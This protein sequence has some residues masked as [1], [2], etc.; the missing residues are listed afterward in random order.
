MTNTIGPCKGNMIGDGPSGKGLFPASGGKLKKILIVYFQRPPIIEYLQKAFKGRGIEAR[1]F[2][3]DSNNWFDQFVIRPINKTAHNLRI[4]PKNRFLFEAHPLCQL[5]YRNRKLI[6]EVDTFCPDLVL[7][8]R[9]YGYQHGTLAEVRRRCKLFGWWIEREEGAE[10]AIAEAALFDYY[11]FLHSSAVTLAKK[12]GLGKI[13]HIPHSVDTG[14]FRP[15]GLA[16]KYDWSFVGGWSEAREEFIRKAVAVSSN[17][18]LYGP[19]WK[20]KLQAAGKAAKG[21]AKGDSIWG[22][23][24]VRLYNESRV[25]INHTHWGLGG[26]RERTGLTMRVLEAA[27]CGSCMLT[28]GSADLTSL[29]TPGKDV[30][31]YKDLDDFSAELKR[32]LTNDGLRER[33]ARTGM[34][35][36]RKKFSYDDIV[37]KIMMRYEDLVGDRG[38]RKGNVSGAGGDEAHER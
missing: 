7:L 6:E 34:E 36:I 21:I 27:A 37:D 9:G 15:L 23:S 19:K 28:D 38:Q 8:I 2:Y 13:G 4:I 24:L 20:K 30:V 14:V 31:L 12:Q 18:A 22:D 1:E 25:V 29:V 11:F 33:I 10:E 35:D 32:L 26:G 17:G 16:K 3:S 5:R